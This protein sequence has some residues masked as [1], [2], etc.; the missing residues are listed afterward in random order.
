MPPKDRKS[1]KARVAQQKRIKGVHGAGSPEH[2]AAMERTRKAP[3]KKSTTKKS[4]T[5]KTTGGN[6]K[7]A[8]SDTAARRSPTTYKPKVNIAPKGSKNVFYGT[9]IPTKGYSKADIR[10]YNSRLKADINAGDSRGAND[11]IFSIAFQKGGGAGNPR[12]GAVQSGMYK[13]NKGAGNLWAEDNINSTNDR[14][15]IRDASGKPTGDE[16]RFSDQHGV[17]KGKANEWRSTGSWGENKRA[18]IVEGQPTR[19]APP[20]GILASIV[21]LDDPNKTILAG[22]GAGS[23]YTG[24]ARTDTG[25]DRTPIMTGGS[26]YLA[27]DYDRPGFQ[28]WSD[29]APPEM[30]GTLGT[31]PAQAGLLERGLAAY[32]P[33]A[34]PATPYQP[35]AGPTYATR[36]SLLG[37]ASPSVSGTGDD[38]TT[39]DNGKTYGPDGKHDNYQDWYMDP[40]NPFGHYWALENAARPGNRAIAQQETLRSGPNID[41][42]AVNPFQGAGRDWTAPLNPYGT[43]AQ[44]YRTLGQ[45]TNINALRGDIADPRSRGGLLS[46]PDFS[47]IPSDATLAARQSANQ[48]QLAQ[49]QMEAQAPQAPG[50]GLLSLPG[51]IPFIPH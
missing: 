51:A 25:R 1:R 18:G 17:V 8:P 33:W 13:L 20:S 27:T 24:D 12:V 32:Q 3:T 14:Y 22:P 6:I 46:Q 29:L 28:D 44:G 7:D 42:F 19:N 16:V 35:P 37:G 49:Q 15:V 39:T 21:D 5:K 40:D 23:R 38:D 43:T 30:P 36:A 4:T 11:V 2:L 10:D 31:A 48:F 41:Q 45:Q 50:L 26:E 47:G 34:Q 9:N